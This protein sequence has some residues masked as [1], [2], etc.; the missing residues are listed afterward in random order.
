MFN[1][2]KYAASGPFNE[3]VTTGGA[4]TN[5]WVASMRGMRLLYA[6]D[7]GAQESHRS[8]NLSHREDSS[9][10]KV[11]SSISHQM[12]F[13]INLRHDRIAQRFR[14]YI[15]NMAGANFAFALNE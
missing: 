13:A 5:D 9:S 8:E 6:G 15:G 2:S 14:G 10:A 11:S 1:Q 4:N 12:R 7:D 3:L